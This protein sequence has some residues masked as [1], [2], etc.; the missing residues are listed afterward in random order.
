MGFPKNYSKSLKVGEKY[1]QIG[2]SVAINVV[3]AIA[4]QII[5]QKLLDEKFKHKYDQ[6]DNFMFNDHSTI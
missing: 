6:L 1:K 4:D 5:K 3:E 2:N